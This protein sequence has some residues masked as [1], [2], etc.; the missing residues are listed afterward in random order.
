[1]L[2]FSQASKGVCDFWDVRF[3]VHVRKM[4]HKIFVCEKI[5]KHR[6]AP[7]PAAGSKLYHK[8]SLLSTPKIKKR[9]FLLNPQITALVGRTP[10]AIPSVARTPS[11]S[12]QGTDLGPSQFLVYPTVKDSQKINDSGTG[13]THL[14]SKG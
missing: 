3:F 8:S 10:R 4:R 9:G 7:S 14:L 11:I 13:S 6:T 1:M 12:F 2:I 5:H